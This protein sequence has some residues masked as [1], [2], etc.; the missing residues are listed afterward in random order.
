MARYTGVN[1][2]EFYMWRA[3]FAF[4]LSDKMLSIE[5]QDLL[6]DYRKGVPFSDQQLTTLREDFKDPQDV[7][8][9]YTHITS[10][11]DKEHFCAMVRALAWCEGDLDK[12]DEYILKRVACL[13]KAEGAEILK[14]SRAHPNLQ[15]YF[16]QYQ[17]VGMMGFMP[18]PP[19]L[20]T[21]A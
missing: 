6:N 20:E 14:N 7:E 2:S 9:L 15:R 12:Q 10:P 21:H 5:E 4:A 16:Q 19:I 8:D 13:G 3:V 1:E 17:R 11:E 18:S